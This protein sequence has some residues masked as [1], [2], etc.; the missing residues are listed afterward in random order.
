MEETKNFGE[1]VLYQP[2]KSIRLEVRLD[3]ETVWLNRQ[4]MATLFD[5][6]IKTIGKHINNALTEELAEDSDV[7][8]FATT[9]HNSTI[10]K[11]A[12]VQIEGNRE[13]MRNIEYYSLDVILSVGYRVKSK[14][15]I[16]FRQWANRVLKDYLLR[17]YAVSHRIEQVERFALETGKQ[18]METN[19]KLDFLRKY[20]E[21]IV[22]DQ[23]DINED[24]R[25]QLEL[26]NQSLAELQVKHRE[27]NKPRRQIGFRTSDEDGMA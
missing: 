20:I 11:F 8:K 3:N 16:K 7:A 27:W 13:V 21:D 5:R 22:T 10:A 2:D 1:I 15:G 9:S 14:S 12:T 4:Q 18:L 23:N 6:D 26:I 24:T 19:V 25:I 17:G